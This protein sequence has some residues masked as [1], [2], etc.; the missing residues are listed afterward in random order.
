MLFFI[1]LT[2]LFVGVVCTVIYFRPST[3]ADST[4]GDI[5]VGSLVIGLAGV[6]V[7]IGC[8]CGFQLTAEA[9]L[10]S[11][12]VE[13]ASLVYQYE[14]DL[15]DNDNDVG[16]KEL[17]TEIQDFNA[18]LVWHKRLQ[19]DAWVGIYVP[20]IYDDLEVIDISAKSREQM[21][22]TVMDIV[23]SVRAAEAAGKTDYTTKELIDFLYEFIDE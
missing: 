22:A 10:D 5:G 11:L 12:E 3:S 4:L 18:S 8:I 20:N 13:R 21:M 7:S 2:V 17:M 9:K 1:F 16:K 15:Y 6:L 19:R 14:N 23:L